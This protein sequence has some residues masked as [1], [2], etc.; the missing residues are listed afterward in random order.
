M[1]EQMN[2]VVVA[3]VAAA[4]GLL[5]VITPVS[6]HAQE[7]TEGNTKDFVAPI[8]FQAAGPSVASILSTV[9]EYRTAL[10]DPNNGNNPPGPPPTSGRREIN[11]DGGNPN[12][13]TTTIDGT[14]LTTFLLTRGAFITTLGTAFIQAPP[15]GLANTFGNPTYETIFRAFSPQRLFSAIESNLTEVHFFVPG[16]GGPATTKGFGAVF[17]DVDQPNGSGPGKKQ[18]DRKASTLIEYFGTDGGLLFSSFV[19]ASPGDGNFSFFGIVFR[20]A[21]IAQVRITSG[22]TAP[23]PNDDRRHDVVMMDDFLYAEPQAIQ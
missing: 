6:V 7:S 3:S 20:D 2:I 11:W 16:G 17:T 21:R 4:F 18:G 12:N 5:S 22:D 23:G 14:P 1:K 15:S 8:V 13:T 19:P 10:G 9:T